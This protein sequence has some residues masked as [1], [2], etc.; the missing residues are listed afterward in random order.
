[1]PHTC[2]SLS[3]T[4]AE[5]YHICEENEDGEVLC[6]SRERGRAQEGRIGAVKV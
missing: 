5:A 4:P 3:S 2:Y 6:D 1:M